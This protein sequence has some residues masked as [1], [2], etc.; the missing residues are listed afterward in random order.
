MEK[1]TIDYDEFE[2]RL[3]SA[4]DNVLFNEKN[5]A[6][7]GWSYDCGARTVFYEACSLVLQM[8]TE[9]MRKKLE[10]SA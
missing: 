5:P 7:S 2:A 6:R 4:L 3:R 1:I 10:A 9:R 8:D